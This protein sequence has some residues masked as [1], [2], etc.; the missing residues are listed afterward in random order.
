MTTRNHTDNPFAMDSGPEVSPFASHNPF[1]Q[2]EVSSAATTYVLTKRGPD[3]DPDEFEHTDTLAVEVMILWG[4]NVLHVEHLTPPRSYWVG[5]EE[6]KHLRNDFLIP[7]DRL[8]APRA[9]VVVKDEAGTHLVILRGARGWIEVPGQGRRLLE[10]LVAR[11]VAEPCAEVEGAHRV[12]LPF[13]AKA[14]MTLGDLTFRVNSV[15]AG[16][17]AVGM[18]GR[19]WTT[20]LYVGLSMAVHTGMIAAMAL[21]TPDLGLADSSEMTQDQLYLMQQYLNATAEPERAEAE[22]DSIADDRPDDRSGG[23]GQRATGAEGSMGNPASRNERG[24]YGIAGDANNKDPQIARAAAVD[25]AKNFGLIGILNSGFAGDPNS[26]T[27]PWGQAE[28]FGSDMIGARGNMWGDAI[29]DAHGAGGLGLSGIGEGGNGS[30]EGIGL[31]SIGNLGRGAGWG[32]GQGIGNGHGR[33]SGGRAPKAPKVSFVGVTS[34]N[35][36]IPPEVI[37]RI[38]RQNYGRFRVCYEAGLRNNPDLTGR[39]SVRFVIGRDGAVSQV[40][41][42]GSDMP[43]PDVVRCV[44][45]SFYG[46]SFPQPEGGIVTVVYPI[47]FSPGG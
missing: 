9:P 34:V 30:G 37:Q 35:G 16:R 42:A 33:L 43:N 47:M 11:G 5:E 19:D 40:G 27:A 23:T 44:T 15:R 24:A 29:M 39:V 7:Q 18:G 8:G 10:N 45:S 3:V 28:S 38:V 4:D 21:F 26:P 6:Q 1:E 2:G 20:S 13:G 32:T 17:K 25:M 22:A 46:L 14:A 41:N 12:E 31:G 36:R